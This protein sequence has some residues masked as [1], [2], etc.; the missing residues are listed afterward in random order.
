[1]GGSRRWSC[2]RLQE[3]DFFDVRS[4]T[5]EFVHHAQPMGLKVCHWFC[6]FG[7]D[8]G[9][10]KSAGAHLSRGAVLGKFVP[11]EG[12]LAL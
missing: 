12:G 9:V 5:P 8:E 10:E 3:W 1:M 4:G 7:K 6:V 11:T 2:D